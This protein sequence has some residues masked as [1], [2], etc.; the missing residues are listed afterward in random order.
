M[1]VMGIVFRE[2]RMSVSNSRQGSGE[3]KGKKRIL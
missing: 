3:A 2:Q 1:K